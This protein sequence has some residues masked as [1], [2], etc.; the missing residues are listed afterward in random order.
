MVIVRTRLQWILLFSF[1]IFLFLIPLFTSAHWVI[2]LIHMG[3]TLIA[4]LGLNILT[5]YSGQISLGQAAFMA[6]GAYSSAIFTT[7]FGLPFW[8][9]VPCAGLVAALIGL[10]FGLPSLRV[11][12]FYL[13]IATLAAHFIIIFVILHLPAATGGAGGLKAPVPKLGGLEFNT[14]T[15]YYY[16]VMT[17]V[18]VMTLF[19]KNLVRTK[20]GR[21]LIALRDNDNAAEAIGVSLLRYKLLAFS[22]ASFYA[23]I[24]GA[25]LAHYAGLIST[26]YFSLLD[27]IWFL[28]IL[29]VGGMG[30][31]IGAIFGTVFITFLEELVHW[32]APALGGVV[33][34]LSW[35]V[36]FPLSTFI[37]GLVIV[38]FLIFEPRGLAHRWE[39]FKNSYR[40]WPYAY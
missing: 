26:D 37:F 39:M 27:S 8:V 2:T 11:K 18:V 31:T 21:A 40:L 34:F 33:P 22:I 6:V 1:L 12:G 28:G 23:G 9:A 10:V 5:G 17:A 7:S 25:L 16:L 24:A 14:D 29:V 30:T 35:E 19:A 15:S 38:L 36:A 32:A 13:A 4:V 3:I 20:T